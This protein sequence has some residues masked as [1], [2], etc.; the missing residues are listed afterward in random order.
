MDGPT[1]IDLRSGLMEQ[2]MPV[3]PSKRIATMPRVAS[4]GEIMHHTESHSEN[5][6]VV[7]R[8]NDRELMT[9]VQPRSPVPVIPTERPRPEPS[10]FRDCCPTC[11]RA[12]QSTSQQTYHRTSY[13]HPHYFLTLGDAAHGDADEYFNL[14]RS[15]F[16][17]S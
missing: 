1:R 2:G 17:A 12:Y 11:G 9:V 16:N 8:T 15:A 10:R 6:L 4:R 5:R 3:K 14:A 13:V 7:Y